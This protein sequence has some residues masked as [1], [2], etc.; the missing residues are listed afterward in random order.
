MNPE[1]KAERRK[2]MGE[3]KK[4]PVRIDPKQWERLDEIR[5]SS[6]LKAITRSCSIFY[7]ASYV[8]P[9]LPMMQ[10]LNQCR[11]KSK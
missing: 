5:K 9:I 2:A 4:V 11:K 6:S 7:P 1:K 3:T 10:R 8:L